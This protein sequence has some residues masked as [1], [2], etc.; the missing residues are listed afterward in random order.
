MEY[1]WDHRIIKK[2]SLLFLIIKNISVFR[3]QL[4]QSLSRRF[5]L[6]SISAAF[7]PSVRTPVCL[8]LALLH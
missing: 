5:H 6:P 3:N 1:V 2:I 4:T 8:D 7:E